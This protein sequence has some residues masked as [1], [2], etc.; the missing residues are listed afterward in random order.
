MIAYTIKNGEASDLL[1]VAED[2]Q[3]QAGEVVEPGDRLP[4]IESLHS[5]EFALS[6]AKATASRSIDA[7]AESAR[8]RHITPGSGQAMVYLAK[9]ADARAFVAASY[10]EANL[11]DYPWVQAE[12]QATG[13]TAPQ[14]ADAIVTQANAWRSTGATIE[15][16]RRAGKLA[17]Q[18][19]VDVAEVDAALT[20]ALAGLEAL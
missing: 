13:L 12:A 14:A 6:Q 5:Q 3:P 7:A 18:A 4:P 10:P 1:L 15:Q 11:T 2:Y 20:A 8:Q 9:E 17:A 16:A 19:A